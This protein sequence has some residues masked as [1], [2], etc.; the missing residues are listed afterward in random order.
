MLCINHS[1]SF[2]LSKEN[3]EWWLVNNTQKMWVLDKKEAL[4]KELFIKGYPQ[5]KNAAQNKL[6]RDYSN[7]VIDQ[8]KYNEVRN[9][10]DSYILRA[11]E[12]DFKKEKL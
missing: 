7:G 10:I 12:N 1:E 5:Y 11:M 6:E 3:V 4:K 9:N 2:G 8:A